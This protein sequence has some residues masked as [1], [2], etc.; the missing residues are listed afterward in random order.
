M[1]S[2]DEE[3]TKEEDMKAV[4]DNIRKKGDEILAKNASMESKE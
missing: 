1:A 4:Y 2:L 3:Y